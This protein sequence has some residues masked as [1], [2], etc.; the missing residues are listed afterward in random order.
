MV[1]L[2][3]VLLL[4]CLSVLALAQYQESPRYVI[5]NAYTQPTLRYTQ[6]Q[7]LGYYGQQY[8]A[9]PSIQYYQPI[10]NPGQALPS[11]DQERRGE[12]Q[13][14]AAQTQQQQ[15]LAW[16]RQI[17]QV[18][19]NER[20]LREKTDLKVTEPV[21]TAEHGIQKTITEPD[22][23]FGQVMKKTR[24]EPVVP[25]GRKLKLKTDL[26]GIIKQE[27]AKTKTEPMLHFQREME[28]STGLN[29]IVEKEIEKTKSEPVLT[30]QRQ[31]KKKAD[32]KG[33]SEQKIKKTKKEAVVT[34]EVI[35]LIGRKNTEAKNVDKINDDVVDV[36]VSTSTGTG[37]Y[38][39]EII[40]GQKEIEE[41]NL[42]RKS[43]YIQEAESIL[44]KL[45]KSKAV[46]TLE[47]D[48]DETLEH[49]TENLKET[50]F[51][52]DENIQNDKL[53]ENQIENILLKSIK[54]KEGL[55]EI[56]KKLFKGK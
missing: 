32:L 6:P 22:V 33:T 30:F 49:A 10:D 8:L 39:K 34:F 53:D 50:H 9:R 27:I 7:I 25:F 42:Y 40:P 2:P 18:K 14:K 38:E 46:N 52:K 28:K 21:V 55:K 15:R 29:A 26:N 4:L 45:S 37:K 56:I 17:D 41:S 3:T 48:D 31:V 23:T 35:E 11:L 19:E 36:P 5:N 1:Q 13:V 47:D 24:T 20:Q 54:T 16:Q 51:I 12:L 44:K 43:S